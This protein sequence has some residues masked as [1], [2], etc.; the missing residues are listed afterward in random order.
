MDKLQRLEELTKQMDASF[1]EVAGLEAKLKEAKENKRMLQEDIIPEA[2]HEVGQ[3]LLKLPSGRYLSLEH[4]L[5]VRVPKNAEDEAYSYLEDL[6]EGGMIK[7][8]VVVEFR[9][10][11]EEDAVAALEALRHAGFHQA[12]VKKSHHWNTLQA[13]VKAQMEDGK[14]VPRE[15]FGIYERDVAQVKKKV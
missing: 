9:Q 11:Q 6:G 5:K 7:R 3:D 14:E 4:E 15:L 8:S 13:W 2:M 10:D 12:F 1:E